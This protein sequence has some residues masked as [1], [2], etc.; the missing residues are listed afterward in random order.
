MSKVIF[1]GSQFKGNTITLYHAEDI[2][3]LENRYYN[4]RVSQIYTDNKTTIS[5]N[6]IKVLGKWYND[7][8]KTLI[9]LPVAPTSK[10]NNYEIHFT[11]YLLAL[12]Y[13]ETKDGLCLQG[14][15]DSIKFIKDELNW[16]F[17]KIIHNL[18]TLHHK[19]YVKREEIDLSVL[20]G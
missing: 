20:L 12:C 4:S 15:Y 18:K 7:L 8:F 3:S 11:S 16:N 14:N 13:E 10:Y 1:K 19:D 5:Y 6:T 17:K 2:I 9:H